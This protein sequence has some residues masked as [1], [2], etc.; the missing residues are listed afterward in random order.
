MLQIRGYPTLKVY[1]AGKAV[2]AYKGALLVA[3]VCAS[4]SGVEGK[5]DYALERG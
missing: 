5:K 2:D 1:H 4:G 3:V